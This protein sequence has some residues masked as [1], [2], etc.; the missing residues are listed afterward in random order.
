MSEQVPDDELFEQMAVDRPPEMTAAKA[1]EPMEE[2][3]QVEQMAAERPN[4]E[5]SSLLQLISRLN[6]V[7]TFRIRICQIIDANSRLAATQ[8]P[9]HR[10]NSVRTARCLQARAPIEQCV[11]GIRS[12]ASQSVQ[13][14]A[15]SS[16]FRT[17]RGATIRVL[18]RRVQTTS[19]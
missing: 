1:A 16:A 14:L 6:F 4:N 5:V 13:S 8:K 17:L 2:D 3:K 15:I 9:S 18:L 19:F 10:L 11:C 12:M 7:D